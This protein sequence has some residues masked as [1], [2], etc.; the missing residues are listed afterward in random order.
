MFDSARMAEL[1]SS[2]SLG[3][4]PGDLFT[5]YASHEAF[6]LVRELYERALRKG[7]YPYAIFWDE[8]LDE[9]FMELADDSI[10]RRVPQF[11]IALQ[12]EITARAFI[13]SS[14]H[15]KHLIGVDPE[16][17]GRAMG[18]RERL[19]EIFMERQSSGELKWVV[20]PYPTR[21]MAQ[22][23]GMGPVEFELFVERACMLDEP[24]PIEAWRD[25]SRKQGS[26]AARLNGTRTLEIKGEN[27]NLR[28]SVDGRMWVND[29]GE[30]NMPG[31]EVF[32]GP[33]EESVEGWI[34]FTYPAVWRGIVVEGVEL[35]FEGG[36]VVEA[37]AKEGEERL[38]KILETDPG[39]KRVGEL[40]FGL[41]D[42]I[43]RFTRMILFD[44]KI[45]GTMHIAL[46]ASYPD[47]GGRNK[48]AIHWDMITDMGK[49]KVYADGE[50]IYEDGSFII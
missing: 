25:R 15:T 7:A 27:V 37:R 23:A 29:A 21:A 19:T 39:A 42:R 30:K 9:L 48:S 18:A 50:P 24:D 20:A 41:N 43:N 33:V 11:L 16:R 4:R 22:E 32:T 8:E 47:T 10:L 36:T 45:G 5:I 14:T 40:A 3:L 34:R 46:G 49:S 26:I 12:E 35:K 31:G 17:I 6:Q 1:L 28:A 13:L 2:Y 44:E 38:L